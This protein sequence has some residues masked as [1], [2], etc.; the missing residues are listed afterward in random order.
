MIGP[1]VIL[2]AKDYG[3]LIPEKKVRADGRE[4]TYWVS[5]EDRNSG[6][7][8]GQVDLF[9]GDDMKQRNDSRGYFDHLDRGAVDYQIKPL[10]SKFAM[11]DPALAQ[12]IEA[13][14][15]NYKFDRDTRDKDIEADFQTAWYLKLM[16]EKPEQADDLQKEYNEKTDRL[17]SSI[18]TR[19]NAMLKLKKGVSVSVGKS[20]G[21]VEGFSK[22]GFPVVRIGNEARPFLHE[23]LAV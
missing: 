18:S 6:K 11:Y 2:K 10:V 22:R 4:V 7:T 13:K 20:S 12:R 21:V 23:E 19:K 15:Q 5:P 1:M 16:K 9:S 3:K 17:V 8:K 14:Y